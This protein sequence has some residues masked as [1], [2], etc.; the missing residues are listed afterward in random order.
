[1]RT[2]QPAALRR[3]W[4]QPNQ[5]DA[6]H[7][8]LNLPI[9]TSNQL[10]T[11]TPLSRARMKSGCLTILTLYPTVLYLAQLKARWPARRKG[12]KKLRDQRAWNRWPKGSPREPGLGWEGE[13]I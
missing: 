2:F 11:L 13:D 8:A 10:S 3:E 12:E 7:K 9:G 1:M 5:K 6:C 4:K